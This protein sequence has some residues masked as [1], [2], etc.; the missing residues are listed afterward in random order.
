MKTQQAY[1]SLGQ[2][3]LNCLTSQR[4]YKLVNQKRN[5]L[6]VSLVQ[7]KRLKNT[8]QIAE[9]DDI[10][11]KQRRKSFQ[12]GNSG[13][14]LLRLNCLY[15][16]SIC[17]QHISQKPKIDTTINK[18]I[19]RKAVKRASVILS[20]VKYWK[21]H[22]YLKIDVPTMFKSIHQRNS[23]VSDRNEMTNR[24]KQRSGQHPVLLNQFRIRNNERLIQYSL[25]KAAKKAK[26][27]SDHLPN[28]NLLSY[29]SRHSIPNAHIIVKQ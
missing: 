16:I 17:L 28:Y 10:P 7:P 12:E 26:S 19:L 25:D 20:T 18:I 14:K 13:Q 5:S 29:S 21:D 11:K 8:S 23:Y 4:E 24:S 9:L 2:M 1:L 27:A 22:S 15:P 3:T 6:L